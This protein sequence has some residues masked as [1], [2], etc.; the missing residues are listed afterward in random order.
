MGITA[1]ST[2]LERGR[3][4]EQ[5]GNTELRIADYKKAA[6]LP[7][8]DEYARSAQA[9][10]KERLAELQNGTN[11]LNRDRQ[12]AEGTAKANG[13]PEYPVPAHRCRDGAEPRA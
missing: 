3:C 5:K 11:S 10:A 13:S 12:G 6:E 8:K 9:Q 4:H 2:Y 1:P 7:V